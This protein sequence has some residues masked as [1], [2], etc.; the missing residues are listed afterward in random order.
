MNKINKIIFFIVI[1]YGL[2]YLF[3]FWQT[4]LGQTP[5]LDGSENISLAE[6]I[7][8]GTLPKEPFFRSMLYPALLS[9]PFYLG[10][11]NVNDLFW[12][13]SFLGMLCHFG[14]VFA[15]CL[16]VNNLWKNNKVSIIL[17]LFYGLYPPAIFFAAE[18]LDTTISITFMLWSLYCFFLAIDKK[19]NILYVLSGL[20]I[21]ISC[22]LRSNLLPYV[23]IYVAYPIIKIAFNRFS[24]FKSNNFENKDNLTDVKKS[25]LSLSSLLFVILLG[26]FICYY[27]S[28]EFRL[29]PWQ[30]ALNLYPSNSLRANGKYYSHT[31]YL[32][33]RKGSYN[34]TRLEA[35]YIYSKETGIYPP[36]TSRS[37]NPLTQSSL[38]SCTYK[39][40]R[41]N[42]AEFISSCV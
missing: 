27:H 22:L 40:A 29:L 15:I 30:G 3:S 39:S 16:L 9:V 19:D 17:S 23:I 12:F 28:G 8:T 2:S 33:N 36:Y 32:P 10:L 18:P 14:N 35:E 24:L 1:V 42:T 4:P 37:C 21:G 7:A 20:L 11:D 25:L 13:A 38:C 5:V 34:P 26:G 6:K 41:P 31:V